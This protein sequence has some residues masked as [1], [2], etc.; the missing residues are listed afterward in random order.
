M[1]FAR[2]HAAAEDRYAAI[3]ADM[4]ELWLGLARAHGSTFTDEEFAAVLKGDLDLN[5]L[6]LLAWLDR[7]K[8]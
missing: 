5:T 4:L 6:G 8:K 7:P 2:R 1:V 3:R